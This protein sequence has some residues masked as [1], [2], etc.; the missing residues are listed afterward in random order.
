MAPAM[1]E[2]ASTTATHVLA[3]R[4]RVRASPLADFPPAVAVSATATA[5]FRSLEYTRRCAFL[6]ILVDAARAHLLISRREL[7]ET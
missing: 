6:F 4:R 3:D 5:I 7:T 1:A 2:P